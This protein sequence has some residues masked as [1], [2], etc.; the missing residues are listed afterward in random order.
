LLG[1]M[2]IKGIATGPQ[3]MA[4]EPRLFWGL[5]ASAW[6][7]N[8][9][10]VLLSLPLAGI[11]GRV[12]RL[13]YRL[14]VPV[15]VVASCLGCYS[16]KH[17]G[18]DVYMAAACAAVA[19]ALHKLDCEAAPLLLGFV[20][21]PATQDSL[22]HALLLSHGDWGVF[23][24]HPLSAALLLGAVLVMMLMVLLPSSRKGRGSVA[25]EED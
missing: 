23:L 18:S 6:A 8:L 1:A 16:L 19:Y 2:T 20:L 12:L 7:G 17:S 10:L 11:W 13:P 24:N 25:L 9:M 4:S 22:R 15:V 14:L 3:L 21:A 5:I